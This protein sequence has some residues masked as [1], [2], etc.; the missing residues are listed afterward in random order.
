MDVKKYYSET[1]KALISVIEEKEASIKTAA[2]RI[3]RMSTRFSRHLGVKKGEIDKIYLAAS[4]H[5]IGKIHLPD[6][7]IHKTED[8]DEGEKAMVRMHP[9]I[10][11]KILSNLSFLKSILPIVKHYHEYIDGSGFPDGL[12]GDE[13]PLGSR[14]LAV[15][16]AYDEMVNGRP[17]KE[18]IDKEKAVQN[19]QQYAGRRYD[20]RLVKKFLEFIEL[21]DASEEAVQRTQDQKKKASVREA[22]SMIVKRFKEGKIELPV[23]PKVVFQVR[24][25]IQNPMSTTD[26]VAKAIEQDAVIS[27]RLITVC[28]SAV[29]RGA[30]K[31]TTVRQAVPRLGLKQTQSIVT[32][33]ANKNLYQTDNEQ[34]M[35]M[36]QQ[37]WMHSLASAYCA[38][39][40]AQKAGYEDIEKYF[41]IGLVHDIGKS[42]LLRAL[43]D[44][45]QDSGSVDTAEVKKAIQEVHC[46][47]SSAL[48]QRWNFPGEFVRAAKMHDDKT[49]SDATQREILVIN[50]ASKMAY[51]LGY[52]VNVPDETPLAELQ[53]AQ[54]IGLDAEALDTTSGEIR[55]IMQ[56]TVH[57]F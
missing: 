38:K 8:L 12:K 50:C 28:N 32:T 17:G 4:L 57:I 46:D 29:Y 16:D 48:L 43:E 2:G 53:S 5:D 3:A 33:I 10:A 30:E 26:D 49:F 14:I 36:M 24:K 45:L 56:E 11:V 35:E 15:V 39:S 7:I 9:E 13:I 37:L 44:L 18:R 1:V 40:I 54:L 51:S 20:D 41:M 27:T 23:L 47:F 42:L 55:E 25:V 19:L 34:F 22:I 52:N 31:T 6:E 21:A